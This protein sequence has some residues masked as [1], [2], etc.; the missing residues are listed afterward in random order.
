MGFCNDTQDASGR[1]CHEATRLD[2]AVSR[3]VAQ[4]ERTKMSELPWIPTCESVPEAGESCL[5]Y[6]ERDKP[7][8][9]EFLVGYIEKGEWYYTLG[10]EIHRIDPPYHV[11][12]YLL[13]TYPS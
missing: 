3:V 10:K 7:V 9:G 11:S 13:I 12:H 6:I 8:F 1:R 4:D 2:V 5:L